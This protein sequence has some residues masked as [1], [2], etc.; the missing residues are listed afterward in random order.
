MGFQLVVICF[1]SWRYMASLFLIY[2]ALP[3]CRVTHLTAKRT[4]ASFGLLLFE[5]GWVV[6]CVLM[7]H[8]CRQTLWR[9]M[10]KTD[11]PLETQ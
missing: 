10:E 1:V 2:G 3:R 9:Q 8:C 5:R 6:N 4:S 11:A 7:N